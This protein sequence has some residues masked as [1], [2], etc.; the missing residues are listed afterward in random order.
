MDHSSRFE[1][2]IILQ[3]VKICPDQRWR[4]FGDFHL[5]KKHLE[6]R[7]E[8]GERDQRKEYREDI[9]KDIQRGIT[10]VGACISYYFEEIPHPAK[11][12]FSSLN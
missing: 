11:I 4:R 10:P 1:I 2:E 9:K 5:V 3:R 7:D 12:K 6:D 8:K